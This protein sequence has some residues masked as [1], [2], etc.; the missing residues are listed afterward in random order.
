MKIETSGGRLTGMN[1]V[2]LAKIL[3]PISVALWVA[4]A[5]FYFVV[6]R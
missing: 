6:V 5:A 2:K 3:G 4:L 1:L